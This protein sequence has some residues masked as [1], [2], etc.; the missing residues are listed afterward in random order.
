M[1]N[2][3]KLLPIF[4]KKCLPFLVIVI[5]VCVFFWKVFLFREVPLPGDFIV[6]VYYPWLDYKW[7]TTTGVPVK[8]PIT[9]DVVSFTYPMQ[10]LAMNL[11]KKGVWP[12]W[13]PYILAGS[14]LLANFQ[15]S[16]FAP[17]RVVYFL[18]NQVTA[19]SIDVIL[20][21]VLASIFTY[22]LLRHWKLSKFASVFGGIA[23]A[24]SGYNLIFS[25]W[26]G[27]TLAAAFIPLTLL[28]ADKFI[29]KQKYWNGIGLSITLALQFFSGYT[30][31]SV[32]TAVAIGILWLVRII[33][34][35]KWFTKTFFL[36]L[37]CFFGILLSAV[38]ILPGLELIQNSQRIFE[39]HPFEWTFLPW[40]KTITFIAPDYFGNHATY[41]Y[42]G[43]QDY[44]SNTGFVGVVATTLAILAILALIKNREVKFLFILAITALILSFPDP[45]SIFIWQHNILGMQAN[46]AHRATQLFC[47]A[48]SLLA[49]FG[50]DSLVSFRPKWRNL[51]FS[52]FP[53]YLLIFTFGIFAIF[54]FKNNIGFKN[55][56]FPSLILLGVN[57]ALFLPSKISKYLLFVLIVIELFRFG[58]KFEPISPAKFTYPT[59]PVL[60]FLESQQKPFRTTGAKVIPSNLRM[61]Y[62]IESTEGYDTF[63]PLNV[64]EFIAAINSGSSASLPVGRYGIVDND[65]SPLL[66]LV[67]TKYYLA[68]KSDEERFKTT[69]F[70]LVFSDKSVDIFESRTVLPRAFMVYNWEI[71]KPIEDNDLVALGKILDK[72]FSLKSKVILDSE[73]LI[74]AQNNLKIP[75]K[76]SVI[77]KVYENQK[78]VIDITTSEDGLLF[79]SDAYYPGWKAFLDGVETKIYKADF[80]FR[81]IVIPKGEH[82][83]KMVYEP[84]SFYDGL[85]ISLATFVISFIIGITIKQWRKKS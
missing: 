66:D 19:W 69:R 2:L 34:E 71:D 13:N 17:T 31:T 75:P 20:Q 35:E 40:K 72:N 50:L 18:F 81:V 3:K 63:H 62:G 9:T 21:F 38:Q 32:Y 41:N 47:A 77:Y 60:R 22:L 36:G 51:F 82:I 26:N 56:I 49:A 78:S 8:N 10:T 65:I 68:L 11:I 67:N 29:Q 6:G 5:V 64:S 52:L 58:W 42:W 53:S 30:Q 24:F 55:L 83:V 54:L 79:I 59:T 4:F 33:G 85:K 14:T 12:L 43:P 23:Y 48:I 44:T 28:F 7:G 46:S 74:K 45:I 15:S 39:P 27:H 1:K 61:A 70:K 76:N 57:I 73:V 84:K 37:F 16:P 80:A 25:E